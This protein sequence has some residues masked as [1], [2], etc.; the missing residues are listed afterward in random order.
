M[1]K[2]IVYG[3]YVIIDADT[4][5]PSGAIYIEG[6]TIVRTGTYDDIMSQSGDCDVIGSQDHLVTAGFVNAHGH[7]KGVTD[8][9]RGHLDD[10][11][12]TWKF[13]SYPSIDSHLD[14]LWTGVR[15]LESGVTTTMHN[16]NLVNVDA[17]DDEFE[18]T[19]EAY[20]KSGIRLAFA[21]MIVNQNHF[22]YGDNDAFIK[23]L[24]PELQGIC[25][26]M[27][28]RAARFGS[29]QYIDAID[30]L[31]KKYQSG[32]TKIMHGPLAPQW[33]SDDIL[34]EI[35]SHAGLQGLRIHIHV[36]Q[37]QLQ[38][39]FGLKKY[40]KSLLQHL[41]DIGF[42]GEDVT[43]GHCVWLD[44]KDIDLLAATRTSV[45]HHAS[46]NLRVR[47]GIAPVAAML[48]KGVVVGIG[49]DDKEFGDDKDFIQELRMVSKLHRLPSHQL[50]SDYLTSQDCFRM[51]TEAGAEVLGFSD[52]VGTLQPGKQAD[53][54]LI[55]LKRISEPFV[56]ADLD[57]IDLLI[58]RG[59]AMDIDTVLVAG[60]IQVQNGKHIKIDREDLI[61]HL[62]ATIPEDYGE[63][64]RQ[65]NQ[66]FPELRQRVKDYFASW[67][68]EMDA[69]EKDPF[70]FM[71][72]R[73]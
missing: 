39:L 13:R 64:Y 65:S 66:L 23:S 51:A 6:D 7:G 9:Q 54:V 35:K 67:Y 29:K 19:I 43:C 26:K 36:Q 73:F 32:Q 38:K 61:Q 68:P 2:K 45:T 4:V 55:D 20:R 10:T 31:F 58:Y 8:F 62:R 24:S 52:L 56:S 72:N 49:M 57:I 30:R 42:L 41:F 34:H 1:K 59:L 27:T 37:T 46:C 50:D 60:E 53:I 28:E 11:L 16:H 48:K 63:R 3:K 12:E 17:C 22:V 44:E 70:Y 69:I 5:I 25:N 21:P 71:N 15:L 47:N 18:S 14:T 33:V 40:G